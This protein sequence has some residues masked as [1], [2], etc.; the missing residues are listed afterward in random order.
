MCVGLK[1]SHSQ[2]SYTESSEKMA[3]CIKILD[4]ALLKMTPVATIWPP[5]IASLFTYFTTD[6]GDSALKLA[7]P[8]WYNK[9]FVNILYQIEIPTTD[10][11]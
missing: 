9:Y 11:S 3:K 10:Y 8:M 2:P 4:F 7:Y 1:C 6:L 5:L